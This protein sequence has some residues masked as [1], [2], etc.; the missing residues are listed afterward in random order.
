MTIC[1]DMEIGIP[2][3]SRPPYS[4]SPRLVL[5]RRQGPDP[6]G[7][8]YRRQPNGSFRFVKIPLAW[9]AVINHAKLFLVKR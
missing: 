2:N 3:S 5:I 6:V 1:Y 4:D 9:S 8:S 7:W